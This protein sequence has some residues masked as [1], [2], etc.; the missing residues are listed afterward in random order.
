MS[1]VKTRTWEHK[2]TVDDP[3]VSSLAREDCLRALG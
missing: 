2:L 1:G 3:S